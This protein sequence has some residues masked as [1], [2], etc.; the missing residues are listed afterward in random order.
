MNI[1]VDNLMEHAFV[2]S[3]D[4]DRLVQFYSLFAA[5]G[6]NKLPKYLHG[7]CN[8]G[9]TGVENCYLSHRSAIQRAKDMNWPFVC[10]FEDDAYPRLGVLKHL[11]TQLNNIPSMTGVLILG[12]SKLF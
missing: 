11:K 8:N 10:V 9:K 2:I 3:I 12:T 1:T 4:E 6:F 5:H 7:F